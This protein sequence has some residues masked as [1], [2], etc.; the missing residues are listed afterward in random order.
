MLLLILCYICWCALS[1][2]F[3]SLVGEGVVFI[4]DQCTIFWDTMQQSQCGLILGMPTIP[5]ND[6]KKSLRTF[7]NWNCF[8][9]CKKNYTRAKVYLFG[10]Y[11]YSMFETTFYVLP[12]ICFFHGAFWLWY[13]V[14]NRWCLGNIYLVDVKEYWHTTQICFGDHFVDGIPTYKGDETL[15]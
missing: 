10:L 14:H 15:L 3:C 9:I 6:H 12:L 7:L 8:V 1:L 11:S 5:K 4:E 2:V 13:Y